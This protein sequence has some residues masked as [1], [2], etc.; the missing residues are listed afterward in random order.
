MGEL[1]FLFVD[2]GPVDSAQ[3]IA[4]VFMGGLF[5]G[6]GDLVVLGEFLFDG[7]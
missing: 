7:I 2:E 3:V 6:W 5:W 1:E 4:G